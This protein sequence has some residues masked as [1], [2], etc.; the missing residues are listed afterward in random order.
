[1][2]PRQRKGASVGATIST[3]RPGVLSALPVICD[4]TLPEAVKTS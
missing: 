1:M 3:A 4:Q 2:P